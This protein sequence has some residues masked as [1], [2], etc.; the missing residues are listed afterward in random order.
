MLCFQ[1]GTFL[2]VATVLQPG[3]HAAEE[4]DEKTR[5]AIT[6]GGIAIP[7]LIAALVGH[8]H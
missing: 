3:K 4:L 5:M 7:V 8:E 6:I 2:Y 1:G